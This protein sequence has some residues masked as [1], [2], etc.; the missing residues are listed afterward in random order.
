MPDST[1]N[2]PPTSAQVLAITRLCMYLRIETELE[3]SPSNRREARNIIY[4][5][6]AKLHGKNRR[7]GKK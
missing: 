2:L 7:H 6:R 5:L 1:L 4:E 3:C